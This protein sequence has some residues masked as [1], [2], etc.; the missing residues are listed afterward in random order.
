MTENN[1]SAVKTIEEILREMMSGDLYDAVGYPELL[2]LLD[3]CHDACHRYN[4]MLP[5]DLEGR[6]TL[7]RTLLGHTGERFK[8]ISPFMCDYGFNIE[9]GEDFFANANLMILD[10][11]RVTFGDHVFLGPNCSFYTAGHPLDVEQRNRGLE[12][13]LPI[14]VGD[15]V[16]IGGNVTVV[17]GVTIG[18][19]TVIGAGSVVTHDIPAGVLAAGNPCRVIREI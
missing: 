10:E 5:S 12:Y 17:P 18:S 9:V 1:C 2:E 13:S 6:A 8:I 14:T 3:R 7:M 11:A 4:M 19:N 15:N 16:W